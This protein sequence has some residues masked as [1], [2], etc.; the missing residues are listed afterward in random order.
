MKLSIKKRLET[1]ILMT[2]SF[3]ISALCALAVMAVFCLLTLLGLKLAYGDLPKDQYPIAYPSFAEYMLLCSA[4]VY[5]T[6]YQAAAE[7]ILLRSSPY[8]RYAETVLPSRITAFI[9]L[10]NMLIFAGIMRTD[11]SDKLLPLLIVSFLAAIFE[12][13]VPYILKKGWTLLIFIIALPGIHRAMKTIFYAV[14]GISFSPA[15]A[16][17]VSA[18]LIIAG[19]WAGD[20][21][22]DRLYLMPAVWNNFS[23]KTV[24]KA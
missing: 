16:V 21:V 18:V 17:I 8:G 6:V 19:A 14:N 13:L 15:G 20:K 5:M 7:N 24:K 12:I 10:V 22:A 1:V 23:L 9:M 3:K 4:A 11:A 2:S